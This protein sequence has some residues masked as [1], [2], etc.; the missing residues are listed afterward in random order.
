MIFYRVI[1]VN[2]RAVVN[3]SQVVAKRII[4]YN[5]MNGTIDSDRLLGS[6]VN[7]SSLASRFPTKISTSY[8]VS[9]AAVDMLTKGMAL[10]LGNYYA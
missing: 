3:V 6:I 4:Q 7:I 9:K 10:E 8:N 5:K 1:G 2:T